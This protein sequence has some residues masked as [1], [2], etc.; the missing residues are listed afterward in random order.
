[1]AVTHAHV[2]PSLSE[3]TANSPSISNPQSTKIAAIKP[4][5]VPPLTAPRATFIP[6]AT[7]CFTCRPKTVENFSRKSCSGSSISCWI[8]FDSIEGILSGRPW[9]SHSRDV[10]PEGA[11]IHCFEKRRMQ[12]GRKVFSFRAPLRCISSQPSY[13]QVPPGISVTAGT[14]NGYL[15]PTLFFLSF[16]LLFHFS[17]SSSRCHPMI[18]DLS[19]L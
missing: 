2:V 16:F 17:F 3:H 11:H 14:I 13:S 10:L 6:S 19:F 9:Q 8:L 4:T 1:M 15:Y 5:L 12:D 7:C 18:S